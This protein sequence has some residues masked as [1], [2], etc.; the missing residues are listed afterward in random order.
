[1]KRK[2]KVVLRALVSFNKEEVEVTASGLVM[3]GELNV[4]PQEASSIL[5]KYAGEITKDKY[6]NHNIY[7]INLKKLTEVLKS[8]IY[9]END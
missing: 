6:F 4:T 5:K 9:N 7:K 8:E 2:E 1:M 3:L